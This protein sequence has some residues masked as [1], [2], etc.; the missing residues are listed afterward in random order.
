MDLSS[1]DFAPFIAYNRVM[2]DI[3]KSWDRIAEHYNDRYAI[4]C[5]V[6]HYG[7]LCPGED[8]LRLMGDIRGKKVIDMG[9]GGGQ[10]A[11][12]LAK[13]GAR[14]TAVDLSSGQI[15][16]A[17]RLSL[18]EKVS[19]R[20]RR[21]DIAEL[22][23]IENGSLDIALSACAISFIERI[24]LVF[25]E[26]R[27]ILKPNGMFILSDMNPLQYLLDE[28]EGGV[29]FNN[30]Y[31]QRSLPVNWTWEFEK[32]DHAPRFRHYVRPLSL[33]I[34]SLID[35]GLA[36]NKVLE[37]EPTLDTP[38]RGFSEEIMREYPYIAKHIPITF[39]IVCQKP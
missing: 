7:P 3:R 8:G 17:E 29:A 16:R 22:P 4:S 25:A 24:D 12:A 30:R 23:F 14:V 28:T 19:I 1:I 15:K 36:V 18:E 13:M 33:Y 32:L 10:N 27:R 26:A 38:H 31:L 5:E 21:S 2:V 11:V 35:A 6:V 34:N 9:C 37:P 39:V 20:F